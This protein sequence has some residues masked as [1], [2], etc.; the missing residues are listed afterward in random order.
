MASKFRDQT[1]NVKVN[2]DRGLDRAVSAM[3]RLTDSTSRTQNSIR[4]M[5][6]SA[7]Q[8]TRGLGT[9]A[10]P[11]A[12][13]V[14]IDFAKWAATATGALGMIP[15]AATA[16]AAGIGTLQ[17][18]TAGFSDTIKEVRDPEKFAT[19]IQSLAPAAQ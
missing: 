15:A 9:L 12:A 16:A 18:A 4:E 1:V 14:A 6:T 5:G 7:F 2:V 17:L 11:I 3:D 19:A 10:V 13:L 8:T